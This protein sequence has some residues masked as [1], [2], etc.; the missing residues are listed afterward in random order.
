MLLKVWKKAKMAKQV[1]LLEKKK[2]ELEQRLRE[3]EDSEDS[4]ENKHFNYLERALAHLGLGNFGEAIILAEFAQAHGKKGYEENLAK[5]HLGQAK[6]Y[7]YGC[8]EPKH[9]VSQLREELTKEIHEAYGLMNDHIEACG[10]SSEPLPDN[11]YFSVPESG[12][13]NYIKELK[14][15]KERTPLEQFLLGIFLQKTG[16][17]AEA[18]KALNRVVKLNPYF[19][20]AHIALGELYAEKDNEKAEKHLR[21]AHAHSSDSLIRIIASHKFIF[22]CPEKAVE[23]YKDLVEQEPEN[24]LY[25]S[26][27]AHA[28][29][30]TGREKEAETEIE[31][32]VDKGSQYALEFVSLPRFLLGIDTDEEERKFVFSEYEKVKRGAEKGYVFDRLKL[33]LLKIWLGHS[34]KDFEK[35][36]A[37]GN[38]AGLIIPGQILAHQDPHRFINFYEY[39]ILPKLKDKIKPQLDYLKQLLETEPEMS[40]YLMA[41]IHET[42]SENKEAKKYYEYLDQISPNFCE[43]TR[44]LGEL[45]ERLG[46]YKDA[47]R[48]YAVSSPSIVHNLSFQ[49]VSYVRNFVYEGKFREARDILDSND[50][51]SKQLKSIVCFLEK[52][53][54]DYYSSL[55][56]NSYRI[57]FGGLNTLGL[58][59]QT[60]RYSVCGQ[61]GLDFVMGEAYE[62][63]WRLTREKRLLKEAYTH[64]KNYAANEGGAESLT[65]LGNVARH[66]GK[67]NEAHNA[68]ERAKELS[69]AELKN[70]NLEKLREQTS[71]VYNPFIIPH[72]S[73][74]YKTIADDAKEKGIP[75]EILCLQTK[76]HAL[77]EIEVA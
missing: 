25:I 55:K 56:D 39:N 49:R 42:C 16:K 21:E 1:N 29:K 50:G 53:Y 40:L 23:T 68:F 59:D 26:Y 7:R 11:Y 27:L 65:R 74:T 20:E 8:L 30:K 2:Q 9:L 35:I 24:E 13:L 66:L 17:K 44:K 45:Y 61:P 18:I 67:F 46:Y 48:A 32:L 52:Y 19:S 70:M 33:N 72:D 57:V 71:E 12:V 4:N 60:I 22:H 69:E 43:C 63:K 51:L 58:F 75:F 76:K 3:L 15:N 31:K 62:G 36:I 38:E 41:R 73:T 28:L 6:Y 77:K 10:E 37:N 64:Y 34:L 47:I 14:A 54:P 5:F